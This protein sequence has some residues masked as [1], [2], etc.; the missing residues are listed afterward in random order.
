MSGLTLRAE[1][2]NYLAVRRALGFKLRRAGLLLA[3]FVGYLEANQTDTITTENAFAWASLPVNASSDWWGYRLS[4]ARAFARHLHAIDPSTT[5]PQPGCSRPR[6]TGP[7]LTCIP[8]PTSPP[9]WPPLASFAR[10][11]GR[12]LRDPGWAPGGDGAAHR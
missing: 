10:R 5:C 9:S 3:D 2:D 12:D 1:L 11:C 7:R 6:P 8:T 4:V